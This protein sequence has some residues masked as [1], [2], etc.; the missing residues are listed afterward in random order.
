MEA[1]LGF[2]LDFWDYATFAAMS[3]IVLGGLGCGGFHPGPAGPH[4]DRPQASRGRGGLSYGLGRLSCG[5]AVDPGARLGIQADHR[6]R[7]PLPA[8]GKE[9]RNR[10]NACAADRPDA[11]A[12]SRRCR[13]QA[14]SAEHAGMIV[15]L[16]VII[17]ASAIFWL[18]FF[19]FRLLR[20]TPG[21]GPDVVIFRASPAAGV[22]HRPEVRDA[23]LLER[24]GRSAHHPAC[25]A[26]ARADPRHRGAGRRKCLR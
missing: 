3:V 4:R 23:Q 22:R 14:P 9:A 16:L 10:G 18:V 13:E 6:D 11:A 7:R 26:P 24:H 21:L 25:S 20:L 2:E 19:K 5:R 1:L 12:A 17:V 15:A 8:R